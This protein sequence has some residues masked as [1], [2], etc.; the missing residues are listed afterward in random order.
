MYVIRHI[1][2]ITK[3]YHNNAKLTAKLNQFFL[4]TRLFYPLGLLPAKLNRHEISFSIPRGLYTP[5]GDYILSVSRGNN[6]LT[7]SPG[8]YILTTPLENFILTTYPVDNILTPAPGDYIQHPSGII[9]LQHPLDITITQELYT[10][11]IPQG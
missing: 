4:D 11:N 1:T 5:P 3:W 7:T 2:K 8:A 9:Y 6:I 10:H